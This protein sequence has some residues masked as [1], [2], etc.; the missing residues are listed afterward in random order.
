ML[1]YFTLPC[2]VSMSSDESSGQSQDTDDVVGAEEALARLG[3]IEAAVTD[4]VVDID[5][6]A[7]KHAKN[8]QNLDASA[9]PVTVLREIQP[10]VDRLLVELVG[11]VSYSGLH[12]FVLCHEGTRSVYN[13]ILPEDHYG[14]GPLSRACD[15]VGAGIILERHLRGIFNKIQLP[16][17]SP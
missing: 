7:T 9:D 13:P 8:L 14:N 3:L 17:E 2:D 16:G 1:K 6:I 12:P 11:A 10:L 15:C 5:S 4:A